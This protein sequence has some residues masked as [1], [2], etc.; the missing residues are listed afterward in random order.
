MSELKDPAIKLFGKT[1]PLPL[2]Q[3]S[4]AN[5]LCGAE[6]RFDQNLLSSITSSLEENSGREGAVQEGDQVC[7]CLALY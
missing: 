2:K 6:D 5:E 4:C 3:R 7:M 1:I